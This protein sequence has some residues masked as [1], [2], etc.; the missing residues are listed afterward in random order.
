LCCT[1][2]LLRS[3]PQ[4]IEP[5]VLSADVDAWEKS[6]DQKYVEKA[7]KR[8]K[9]GW[10]VGKHLTISPHYRGP[11]PAAIYWTGPGRTI[12]IIRFRAGCIVH[13]EIIEKL[14]TGEMGPENE[15]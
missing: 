1:I 4:I 13:R 8:H 9:V 15:G 14:P 5:D 12:P 3:D 10:N 11:C 7:Y 6:R 2:C